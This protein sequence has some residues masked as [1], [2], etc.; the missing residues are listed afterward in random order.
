MWK[1]SNETIRKANESSVPPKPKLVTGRLMGTKETENKP[2]EKLERD[3]KYID[4]LRVISKYF[5]IIISNFE[6]ELGLGTERTN[7]ILKDME[8]DG[9]VKSIRNTEGNITYE[10]IF[11]PEQIEDFINRHEFIAT[12][13]PAV[14]AV[15]IPAPIPQQ[16]ALPVLPTSPRFIPPILPPIQRQ[17][18]IQ[19][20]LG[21]LVLLTGLAGLAGV[22]NHYNNEIEKK[23]KKKKKKAGKKK[24][25]RG[26]GGWK[27]K[28]KGPEKKRQNHK[29][30]N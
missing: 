14:S 30:N 5:F 26:R 22:A 3:A 28:K 21:K 6:V 9:I 24:E 18:F 4:A 17:G 25:K 13:T 16:P 12:R 15:P 10:V 7:R 27:K 20:N 2:R 11:T 1:P 8:T 29:K 23:K 19:R